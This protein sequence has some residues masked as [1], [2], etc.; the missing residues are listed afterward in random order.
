MGILLSN[1]DARESNLIPCN[2]LF[3]MLEERSVWK[4]RRY[5]NILSWEE[6]SFSTASGNTREFEFPFLEYFE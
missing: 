1:H 5:D 2:S 6:A 3:C 4:G